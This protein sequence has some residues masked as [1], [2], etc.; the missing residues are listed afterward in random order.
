MAR[1]G[2]LERE[3]TEQPLG[4]SVIDCFGFALEVALEMGFLGL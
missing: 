4:S 2:G 1:V 3:H